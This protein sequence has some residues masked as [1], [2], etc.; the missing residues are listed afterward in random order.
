M[1]PFCV[2]T[3]IT[4]SEVRTEGAL[5]DSLLVRLRHFVPELHIILGEESWCKEMHEIHKPERFASLCQ[6]LLTLSFP[7]PFLA[8]QP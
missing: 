6:L 2:T 8:F 4:H 1:H 7:L 5:Y 3:G